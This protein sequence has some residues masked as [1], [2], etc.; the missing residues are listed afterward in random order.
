MTLR[1][2]ALRDSMALVELSRWRISMSRSRNGMKLS[3]AARQSLLIAGYLMPHFSS[4]TPKAA[5]AA[6]AFTAVYT[7][8]RSRAISA[9]YRLDE[10]LK[11]FRIRCTTQ[12]WTIVSLK[13]WL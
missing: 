12:V 11:V 13:R 10:Y 1:N 4:N 5:M 7:G 3:Q 6:S 2:L 9:Q 8:F